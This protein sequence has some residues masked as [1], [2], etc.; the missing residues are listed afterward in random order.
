MEFQNY[1][2]PCSQESQTIKAQ[3]TAYILEDSKINPVSYPY[4][5]SFCII[6]GLP[7]SFENY[8]QS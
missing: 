2:Q 5:I 7:T 1:T 8:F 3:N 6:T 4:I